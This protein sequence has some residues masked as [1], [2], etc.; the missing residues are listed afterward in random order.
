MQTF[1]IS[2]T[3]SFAVYVYYFPHTEHATGKTPE[4]RVSGTGEKYEILPVTNALLYSIRLNKH[5]QSY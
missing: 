1:W 3:G 4:S 2:L 5:F